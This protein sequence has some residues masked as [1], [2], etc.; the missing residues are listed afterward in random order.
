MAFT[1]R[2]QIHEQQSV[3]EQGKNLHLLG[4]SDVVARKA[5]NAKAATAPG[6]AESE[7]VGLALH[8]ICDEQVHRSRIAVMQRLNGVRRAR[9]GLTDNSVCLFEGIYA[10]PPD[11]PDHVTR[12]QVTRS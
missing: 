6:D 3:G 4:V 12:L 8:F 10:M 1:T 5:R 11:H 2:L 7:R 9:R